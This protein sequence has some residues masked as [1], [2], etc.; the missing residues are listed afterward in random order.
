[1][2]QP[3]RRHPG[4]QQPR[5]TFGCAQTSQ[6]VTNPSSLFDDRSSDPTRL[7]QAPTRRSREYA[8][9]IGA[10]C[11][12]T[13]ANATS[14]TGVQTK[15]TT[16]AGAA[17]A[18]GQGETHVTT[19]TGG[20]PRRMHF[21]TG[22][23]AAYPPGDPKREWEPEVMLMSVG[24]AL[25]P[26]AGGPSLPPENMFPLECTTPLAKMT[27]E[28]VVV[29]EKTRVC[30]GA[31][32][33][34]RALVDTAAQKLPRSRAV[35]WAGHYGQNPPLHDAILSNLRGR[36]INS[37]AQN[38]VVRADGKSDLHWGISLRDLL[39]CERNRC[40]HVPPLDPN[41]LRNHR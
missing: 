8:K 35:S 1:M 3:G 15:C 32:F 14:N 41:W 29:S 37:T 26:G 28:I 19:R 38:H 34:R 7:V 18:V 5:R 40:A 13:I 17:A 39:A 6:R 21:I 12:P 11:S 16:G 23:P 36:A 10:M 4:P 30:P 9:E 31:N 2:F 27:S 22:G 24:A 33:P 20:A 25:P